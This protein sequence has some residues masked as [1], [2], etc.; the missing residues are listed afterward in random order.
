MTMLLSDEQRVRG[1]RLGKNG[2]PS[3]ELILS[4]NSRYERARVFL[5]FIRSRGFCDFHSVLCEKWKRFFV[6]NVN[7]IYSCSGRFP[8]QKREA[9]LNRSNFR[10]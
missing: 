4:W 2:E 10:L 8:P 1:M 6:I 5:I 7:S 9:L 3:P